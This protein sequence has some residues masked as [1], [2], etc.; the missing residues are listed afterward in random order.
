MDNVKSEVPRRGGHGIYIFHRWHAPSVRSNSPEL[1]HH[2]T[3]SVMT[4]EQKIT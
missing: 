1:E 4:N 3:H 2:R